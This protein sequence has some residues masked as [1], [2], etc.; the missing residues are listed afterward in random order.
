MKT[1]LR[2]DSIPSKLLSYLIRYGKLKRTTLKQLAIEWRA[3]P[4]TLTRAMRKLCE[5]YPI[6]PFDVDDE[7]VTGTNHIVYWKLMKEIKRDE[8]WK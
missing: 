4:D 3:E 8:V 1:Y 2:P 6:K 5:D 7:V